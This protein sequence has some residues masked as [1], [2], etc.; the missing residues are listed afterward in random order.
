MTAISSNTKYSSRG[1]LRLFTALAISSAIFSCEVD[2]PVKEQVPE[3]ITKVILHFVP[4]NGE[5]PIIATATDPDGEGVADIIVDQEIKLASATTYRL[6]I[7]LINGLA[8]ETQPEYDIT[9]EVREEADE[10]MLFFGWTGNLFVSPAGAGNADDPDGNV[11]Y[12]DKDVNGLPLG[13]ETEWTTSALSTGEL[14]IVLKHQPDLK[15][16]E[17]DAETG[18]TDLDVTFPIGIE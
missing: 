15:S 9:E 17:S 10:H 8:D 18:E 2:D 16:A 7:E 13:L 6:T 11:N 3:L 14:R 12:L 1:R 5:V 4:D